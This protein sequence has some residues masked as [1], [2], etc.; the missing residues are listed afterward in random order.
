MIKTTTHLTARN[1]L[2][3]EKVSWHGIF[4]FRTNMILWA[5]FKHIILTGYWRVEVQ[6]WWPCSWNW[7]QPEGMPQLQQ[8]AVPPEGCMGWDHWAT[9]CCQAWEQESCWWN[10][11]SSWPTWRWRTVYPWTWQAATQAGGWKGRTSGCPGRGWSCPRARGEQGAERP[12]RTWSSQT[13]DWSQDSREGG[14]V[15]QHQVIILY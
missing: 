14:G 15:Q 13:G 2:I 12:A 8:W 9:G 3:G 6:G 5:V 10:Q 1:F 4:L 11:G 7:C